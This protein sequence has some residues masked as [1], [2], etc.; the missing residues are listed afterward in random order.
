MASPVIRPSTPDDADSVTALLR[1]NRAFLQPWEPAHEE[2]WYTPAAQRRE[3]ARLRAEREAGRAAAFL[4]LDGEEPVGQLT[5]DTIR[6]EPHQSAEIRVWV[7]QDRGNK[8]LASAAVEAARA[9]AFGTLGLHR[10]DAAV[11]PHNMVA[12]HLLLATGFVRL[13]RAPRH[14]RING[15]W[16]DHML[17]QLLA[18]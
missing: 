10:L 8:G 9:E 18:D 1:R 6:R 7:S 2:S 13:G 14:Q 4:V 16:Q 11:L 3:L 12:Q 17:F 15:R 5:L